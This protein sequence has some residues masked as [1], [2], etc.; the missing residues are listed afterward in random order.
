MRQ[1]ATQ[2]LEAM[3]MQLLAEL[4]GKYTTFS[5]K[6]AGVVVMLQKPAMY[7]PQDVIAVLSYLQAEV[8]AS[9][10]LTAIL[11]TTLTKS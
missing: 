5:D 2:K 9:R 6:L 3:Q 8:A 4:D 1:S 7:Q 10:S 11:N